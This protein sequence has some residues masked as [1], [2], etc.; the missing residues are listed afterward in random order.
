MGVA[1]VVS[2][3]MTG[4][5]FLQ[6]H[7]DNGRKEVELTLFFKALQSQRRL[8][9]LASVNLALAPVMKASCLDPF[10]AVPE[11]K[12]FA[13]YS[14]DDHY[15]G[16]ACHDVKL[17][18][19]S[20][21]PKKYPTG[22]FFMLDLRTHHA[23]HM[24]TAE[25]G[26]ARKGEHDMRAIKRTDIDVLR[27]G[28]PKGRKVIV[29][30]DPAGIDLAFWQRSKRRSGLYFLSRE[31]ENMNLTVVRRQPVDRTVAENTGVVSDEIVV[32]ASDSGE[33]RRVV[34]TDTSTGRTY[35]YITTEMTL[36]PWVIA[37]IYKHRWDI[38]KVFDEFK[39]KL[40][41]RKSWASGET[42]KTI[43]AQFLCLSH[44]LML[45]LS[46]DISQ[47]AGITDEKEKK[48]R[49]GRME[50]AMENGASF[51]ATLI[52]RFTVRSLKFIRWLRNHIYR[53]TSWEH[54]LERLRHTYATY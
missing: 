49:A 48:R 1:R 31:K 41:E 13:I 29:A 34:Y 26:G 35:T 36:P 51:V 22:H 28:E 37:L 7:A 16:A 8:A 46:E 3:S 19:S 5:D 4:R 20:G 2:E 14:G 33:L 30:W 38:E 53:N 10:A 50:D 11:L 43:H 24:A 44:N 23:R 32:P 54:A 9:N 39:N 52:Q 42:A 27:C 12:K 25:Q 18:G 6:R 47:V 15:H 21:E 17:V 45:L 40:Y